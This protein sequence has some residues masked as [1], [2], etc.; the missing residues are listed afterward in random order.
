MRHTIDHI[1]KLS[2]LMRY[3]VLTSTTHAGSGHPTSC[4]SAVELTSTLFYGGFFHY[5]LTNKHNPHNDRLIFSKGHAAPLFYALWA[6]ADAINS[7]QMSTLREFG[8]NLEGHPT[9][10]F[11]YTDVA[12]GSLGQGLGVGAGMAINAKYLE[13][14]NA[15][16]YVLLGDGEL[17][18]GSNWEA[19][20]CAA[21]YKLDNLTALVDVSRL[22]QAGQSMF[23]WDLKKYKNKFEALG[24]DTLIVHDGHDVSTLLHTYQK[25]L[26]MHKKPVAI[27]AK[28][29]K[30]AGVSFLENKEGWHGKALSQAELAMAIND[31]GNVDVNIRGAVL[32]V[33]PVRKTS[34]ETILS[35]LETLANTT[36]SITYAKGE[37]LATRQAYGN[38]LV[39]IEKKYP[40]MVVMDAGMGNSTFSEL[41]QHK[42]P[43]RFFEMYIAEQNMV[44]VAMGMSASGKIPFISTF[45]SFLTRAHDQFRMAQYS[46]ANIKIAGSHVGVSMGPDGASQMGL[47]DIAMFRGLIDS[48][49]LYPCDAVSCDKLVEETA[50]YVGISYLR[51]TRA[52]TPV[53]YNAAD[54][55]EIGGSKTLVSSGKDAVTIVAAGITL[56][57]A[58]K[59]AASLKEKKINVRVIDLYSIQPMDVKT[60]KK[61]AK[62]TKAIIVVE[63]HFKAGGIGEAVASALSQTPTPVYSLCVTKMPRSGKPED[64]LS[65]ESIDAAAI[66]MKVK[67]IVGK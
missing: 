35:K 4:L 17:E 5:D 14:N 33:P 45:G 25:R 21:H 2:T 61:A 28:T 39:R 62:E 42:F 23:G 26:K 29:I 10:N 37:M 6:G 63:D 38:A 54:R 36:K 52:Q 41:F 8:S 16:I 57:E 47:E 65:Y 12:T 49:V 27:I 34:E 30:G 50:R 13:K 64:L 9:L 7:A 1:Q 59:A 15:H 48:V 51:L 18:E 43:D 19:V 32:P 22:E 24:W 53:I 44:S 31:L 66:V 56:H 11:P 58:L 46:L 3:L 67:Q 55:F 40:K 60:L 20:D